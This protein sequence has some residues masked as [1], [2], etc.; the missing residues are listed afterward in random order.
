MKLDFALLRTIHRILR[1]KTDLTERIEKG[2]RRIVVAENAEQ[3]F[4]VEVD[5]AKEQKTKTQLAANQKQLQLSER[6]ARVEELK[7]KLNTAGSNKE[8]QLLKDQIAADEQANLV[9]S[10][11]IL[12]ML[13]RLDVLE[14][15]LRT[16]S[17]NLDKAKNETEKTRKKVNEELSSLNQ[18]LDSVV[19]EL[20][21]NEKK[22]TGDV[23]TEYRRQAAARGEEALA[24][25]DMQ[26]CGNCCTKITTQTMSEL[27]MQNAV[28]CQSCGSLLYVNENQATSN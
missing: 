4:A 13:E 7:K 8:F 2:P 6:E 24:G 1:Q 27:M 26:T 15:S 21:E 20:N 10:D 28:F 14:Q 25:T 5:D 17:E 16:A 23:G 3:Q 18:Q 22:L 19:A 11:E 12:E 9:L